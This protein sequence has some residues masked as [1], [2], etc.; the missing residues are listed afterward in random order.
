MDESPTVREMLL[1]HGF[2]PDERGTDGRTLEGRLEGLGEPWEWGALDLGLAYIAGGDVVW[3][4]ARRQ[5]G[6]LPQAGAASPGLWR[7]TG[8]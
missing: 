7:L 8:T 6:G 4:R 3:A 1:S 2:D 5:V